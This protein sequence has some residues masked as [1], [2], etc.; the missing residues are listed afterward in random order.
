[1]KLYNALIAVAIFGSAHVYSSEQPPAKDHN[2]DLVFGLGFGGDTL[3]EV[4]FTDGS[5]DEIKAGSGLMFGLNFTKKIESDTQ[6]P[7]FVKTGF[8]YIFDS[9]SAENGDADF[10]RFPLEVSIG[11][12]IKRLQISAGATYHINP[13]LD[14]EFDG[15]GSGKATAENAFGIILDA[16]YIIPMKKRQNDLIVGLKYTNIEYDFSDD[17]YDGS[18]FVVTFGSHY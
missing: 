1:M 10:S 2:L 15:L 11:T 18:G 14:I 13:A 5:S 8:N 12:Q 16:T 17:S 7:L 4:E 6:Q 3:A 9:I